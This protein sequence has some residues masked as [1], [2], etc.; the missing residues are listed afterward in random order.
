MTYTIKEMKKLTNEQKKEYKT[1]EYYRGKNRCKKLREHDLKLVSEK[2]AAYDTAVTEKDILKNIFEGNFEKDELK[3]LVSQGIE[4]KFKAQEVTRD[5][6]RYIKS[7]SRHP[8]IAHTK[9]FMIGDE[10]VR[11]RPDFIF[12][13]GKTVEVVFIRS[14]RP[15]VSMRGKKNDTGVNQSLELWYGIIYG[16]AYAKNVTNGVSRN[17]KS[18]YY[19]MRKD[20]D[21]AFG[22]YDPDFFSSSGKNVVFLYETHEE[23]NASVNAIDGQF[24]PQLE[25]FQEGTECSAD[26]CKTCAN[27]TSCEYQK[28]PEPFE[29]KENKKNGKIE[30]SPA[31][32][33]IVAFRKGV[34][35]VI[36][37]AGSGKT[38]CSTE[39]V[40]QMYAEGVKPESFLAVTFTDAGAN[41]MKERIVK[42]CET[43]GLHI[44]GDDIKAM[45]FHKFG[46]GIIQ[47]NYQMFGYTKPP[48]IVDTNDV[49]KKRLFNNILVEEDM[50]TLQNRFNLLDWAIR[51]HSVMKANGINPES[52]D[53]VE[54]VNE[55]MEDT[56]QSRFMS[57]TDVANLMD[58]AV[59]FDEQLKANNLLTFADIEPMMNQVLE[60][61][62]DYLNSLGIKHVLGDEFQDSNDAQMQTIKLLMSVDGF[63]SLMV[64]GDDSQS[65]YGFRHTS[66]ENILH[67]F[68]KVGVSGKDFR[69][70]ENRRSTE[71][72]LS[73]ANRIDALNE[74]RAGGD[75]VAVRGTGFKPVVRA[76]WKRDE[77]YDFIVDQIQ[78]GIK[79]GKYVPEEFVVIAYKKSELVA[80]A[81]K[82]SAAGIPWITK[83]PM[84]LQDNSRVQAAISLASAF[85]QPEAESLYFNYLVALN[86]GDIFEDMTNDEIKEKVK[87]LKDEWCGMDMLEIP[88]QRKIFHEK[89]EAIKGDDEIYAAFLELLY[90]NE[91]LQSELE[92][93]IDFR[94]FGETVAK[95]LE[96]DYA[97][98]VLT[99][100]H[101]S[102]GLEWPVVFNTI[103]GYD[104]KRLHRTGKK[105]KEEIEER[106]RLLYVSVTRAR[107]ILYVTGQYVAYGNAREYTYNQ[108]LREALECSDKAYDNTKP[109]AKVS[110]KSSKKAGN[111]EMTEE[112]K[113]EYNKLVSGATQMNIKDIKEMVV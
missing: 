54:K 98:V 47:D 19:F 20:T 67:F 70:D 40:A 11:V 86:D 105:V 69:L 111:S 31:Q 102:K 36:A 17:I 29:R 62:K 32:A 76:Y 58:I 57:L 24:F 78:K 100:A 112:Q 2:N 110:D 12:D 27:R 79:S 89:L 18:S 80:I 66:Q 3:D 95:K 113:A 84:P 23:R 43:R 109:D 8:L 81:G 16:R 33:D 9:Y 45:T 49:V 22:L 56:A 88:Y 68:E 14:S 37:K 26:D 44:A 55:G 92:F 97:G 6:A 4:D 87:E 73:F 77:E 108:F 41:E 39:R 82:L 21:K 28:S 46:L 106:R 38:E 101:S 42:K 94:R 85:Y 90:E 10:K 25:A 50:Y 53:A 52:E 35:R 64:V 1:S 15:D 59:K 72:I 65:I 75:M 99:T 96:N 93:V 30:L 91:D 71:P 104:N 61:K 107:D 103:S 51:V 5:L 7:E 63:E 13:D 48:M 83:Y 60:E 74:N 34:A